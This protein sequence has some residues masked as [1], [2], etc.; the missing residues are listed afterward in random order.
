MRAG[1]TSP[2]MGSPRRTRRVIRPA[3]K[4]KRTH[5]EPADWARMSILNCAHVGRFSSDRTIRE[6]ADEI[7]GVT[8]VPVPPDPDAG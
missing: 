4:L 6:Y 8:P 2:N 1:C 3:L 7:W 5:V